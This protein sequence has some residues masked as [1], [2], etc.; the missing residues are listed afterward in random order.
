[1]SR[2]LIKRTSNWIIWLTQRLTDEVIRESYLVY[3]HLETVREVTVGI[4]LPK[5]VM[6]NAKLSNVLLFGYV[7]IITIV[8]PA[9]VGLWWMRFLSTTRDGLHDSTAYR[10]FVAA[11]QRRHLDIFGLITFFSECYEVT[12][13]VKTKGKGLDVNILSHLYVALPTRREIASDGEISVCSSGLR[14][15]SSRNVLLRC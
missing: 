9:F 12:T 11:S 3:G 15:N 13:I 14:S 4:A 1:M 5:K 2:K 8:V 7:T 10:F 6:K